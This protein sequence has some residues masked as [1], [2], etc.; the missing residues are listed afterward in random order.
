[1]R[2]AINSEGGID[3]ITENDTEVYAM[4]KLLEGEPEDTTPGVISTFFDIT[5]DRDRRLTYSAV[6]KHEK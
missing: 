6:L 5:L 4:D 1:M 3:L 2:A